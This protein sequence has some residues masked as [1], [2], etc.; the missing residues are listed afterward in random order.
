MKVKKFSF[1]LAVLLLASIQL[2]A[3]TS[4]SKDFPT[5]KFYLAESSGSAAIVSVS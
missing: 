2:V 4:C 5:G 1:M 3:C